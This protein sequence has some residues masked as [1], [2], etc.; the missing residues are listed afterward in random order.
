VAAAAALASSPAV[1]T[2][3]VTA[4][5]Q[6]PAALP[7]HYVMPLLG[8]ADQGPLAAAYGQAAAAQQQALQGAW[9]ALVAPGLLRG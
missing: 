4:Q 1:T 8:Q 3:P 6:A 7:A 9:D 5:Q 2:N